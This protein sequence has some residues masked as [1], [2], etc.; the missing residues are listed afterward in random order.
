M[1]ASLPDGE[2]FTAISMR[3]KPKIVAKKP[4]A[5]SMKTALAGDARVRRRGAVTRVQRVG[6]ESGHGHRVLVEEAARA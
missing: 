6:V 3:T 2:L 5:T 4:S 1:N